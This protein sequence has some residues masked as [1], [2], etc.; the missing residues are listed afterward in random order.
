MDKVL[1][2]LPVPKYLK[3]VLEKKYGDD[4]QATETTLLGFTVLQ[5][6]KRKSEIK[7][8]YK[9]QNQNDYFRVYIGVRKAGIKGFIFNQ[10]RSHQLA[11]SLERQTKEDLF[12]SA[13]LNKENYGIE[14]QITLLDFLD[15]YDIPDEEL[16]YETLRKDFNRNKVKLMQKLKINYTKK[17]QKNGTL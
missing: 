10:K 1:L 7:Y 14:Y 13:I 17:G 9:R 16:T 5:I 15:F 3:R 12:T 8:D 11:K 6:L 4:F 2:L